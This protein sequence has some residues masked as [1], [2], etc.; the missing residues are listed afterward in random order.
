ME[1]WYA[2][3]TADGKETILASE[4]TLKELGDALGCKDHTIYYYYQTKRIYRRLNV[5]II[6]CP[7]S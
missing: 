6:A 3:V 4:K 5:R 1:Y 7:V 2:A